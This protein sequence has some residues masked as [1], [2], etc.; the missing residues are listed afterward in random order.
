MQ[1]KVYFAIFELVMKNVFGLCIDQI[2][3]HANDL[4]KILSF[5]AL[6]QICLGNSADQDQKQS[7]QGLHYLQDYP[8]YIYR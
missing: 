5:E 7:D 3:I 6:R 4:F 2:C 1:H 8:A